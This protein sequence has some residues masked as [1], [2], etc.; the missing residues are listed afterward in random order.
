MSIAHDHPLHSWFWPAVHGGDPFWNIWYSEPNCRYWLSQVQIPQGATLRLTARFPHARYASYQTYTPQQ[1]S[2]DMLTDHEWTPAPGADNPYRAGADRAA[3]ERNYTIDVVAE[4]V[5]TEPSDRRPDTLYA[6]SAADLDYQTICYRVYLPDDGRD[7]T[8]GVGIPEPELHLADGRV[9]VGDE[10]REVL[11]LGPGHKYRLRTPFPSL[12]DYLAVRD[13]EAAP[14]GFPATNPLHWQLFIGYP[15][16]ASDYTGESVPE[17]KDAG[18]FNDN[19]DTR[20]VYAHVSRMH[21]EVLVLRGKMPTTASAPN[22]ETRMPGDVQTRYWSITQNESFYTQ[23]GTGVLCDQDVPVDENGWFTIVTS[24]TT[25]R[26]RNA[27]AENG[28]AFLPW[29]QNGDGAGD[30]DYGLLV[31]RNLVPNP[32]FAEAVGQIP[33]VGDEKA[34][35]GDYLPTA[36]YMSR[37]EFEALDQDVTP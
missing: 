25:D 21:G 36:T 16:P 15:Q 9:L 32:D 34:T 10:A 13:Q 27:T 3:D 6:G 11:A 20:Y 33:W 8:G 19:R 14:L 35:M 7:V 31:L 29:P 4:P 30:F 24:T 28:V 26:P 37:Q 23:R 1:R 5:P 17:P 18:G 12:T 2:I 22:G